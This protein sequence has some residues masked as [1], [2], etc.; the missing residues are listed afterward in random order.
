MVKSEESELNNGEEQPKTAKKRVFKISKAKLFVWTFVIVIAAII[1]TQPQ[2]V[3]KAYVYLEALHAEEISEP[4]Q[5]PDALGILN[6]QVSDLQNQ[7]AKL[8]EKLENQTPAT[9]NVMIDDADLA[10]MKERIAAIEKQNL[11]VINS[12]ADVAV[13]LGLL[14]RLD[15]AESKMNKLAKISDDGALI[16]SATM[17][18]KDAVDTGRPY[19]YEAEVLELLA[20]NDEK[21][22]EPVAVIV[23]FA[24]DGIV[25]KVLLKKEFDGIYAR[26]LEQQKAEF[27]KTWKDRLNSKLNEIIKVKRV[28]QEAPEFKQDKTLEEVKNL[29]EAGDMAKA[30]AILSNPENKNLS[31]D[32]ALKEWVSRA[33]ARVDFEKAVSQI[34]VH[35]LALMKVNYIK[36]E[37]NND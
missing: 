19:P 10:D 34:A 21:I 14:T 12:K 27:A 9:A 24:N 17:M 1:I 37:S 35:S 32:T 6:Q 7:L 16:L 2:A 3:K 13:V 22:K 33:A 36:Q 29:V 23:K 26:L 31:A 11:N 8:Q 28:N 20:Q 18:V 5:Q 30:V 15:N 4:Q 25:S